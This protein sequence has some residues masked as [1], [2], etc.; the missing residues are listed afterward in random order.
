MEHQRGI[1]GHVWFAI[2]QT[3]GREEKNNANQPGEKESNYETQDKLLHVTI[4]ALLRS[5]PWFAAKKNSGRM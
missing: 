4:V 2:T 5:L 3:H 1:C